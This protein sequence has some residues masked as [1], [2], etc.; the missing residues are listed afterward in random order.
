MADKK[1]MAEFCHSHAFSSDICQ[2]VYAMRGISQKKIYYTPFKYTM[3]VF[4]SCEYCVL[5]PSSV[6][7]QLNTSLL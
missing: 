1:K 6:K 2:E 4:P 3:S 7:Y 5:S